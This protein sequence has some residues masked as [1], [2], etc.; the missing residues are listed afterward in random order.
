MY[1]VELVTPMAKDLTDFG[2]T[3]ISTKEEVDSILSQKEGTVLVV[4][5]SVCGCA[6]GNA[7]PAAKFALA[8]APKPDKAIT[9]FAGVDREATDT[10]RGYM[11][12]YPPSSPSIALFKDGNLVHMIERHMIEGRSAQQIADDLMGALNKYCG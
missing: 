7:R 5:N 10:A 6:A 4:V 9:V 3:G 12:P 2:F 8:N 1:P 11:M